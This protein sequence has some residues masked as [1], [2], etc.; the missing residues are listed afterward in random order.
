M[1][2]PRVVPG[3]HLGQDHDHDD[4]DGNRPGLVGEHA[5]SRV[6]VS[7]SVTITVPAGQ[8]LR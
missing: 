8:V 2:P 5:K 6:P 3:S 1:E 4:A 7:E